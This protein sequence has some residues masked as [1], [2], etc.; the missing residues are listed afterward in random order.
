MALLDRRRVEWE[1]FLIDN[2]P[3]LI[4]SHSRRCEVR[5]APPV[6]AIYT[7]LHLWHF[8][9]NIQER[10]PPPSHPGSQLATLKTFITIIPTSP[11]VHGYKLLDIRAFKTW[12]L[13]VFFWTWWRRFSDSG[14]KD[15]LDD[16]QLSA[17]Y[18]ISVCDCG[19]FHFAPCKL[20]K[21]FLQWT[22]YCS[23]YQIL[24]TKLCR[25]G[26]FWICSCWTKRINIYSRQRSCSV[27]WSM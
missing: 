26:F 3:V 7:L 25:F 23:E 13:L 2:F 24:L 10:S 11:P 20:S 5:P 19:R 14:V 21:Y 4:C 16:D 18:N 15:R 12:L 27:A 6:T 9:S 8:R 22:P 17:R 1:E